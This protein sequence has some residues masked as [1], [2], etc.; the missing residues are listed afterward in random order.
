VNDEFRTLECHNSEPDVIA[1]AQKIWYLKEARMRAVTMHRTAD[2]IGDMRT[3]RDSLGAAEPAKRHRV[4]KANRGLSR[5]R[6]WS[7]AKRA[8]PAHKSLSASWRN[9]SGTD[10]AIPNAAGP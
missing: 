3:V 8:R 5:A 2:V 10:C 4:K 6:W 7:R 1:S 9:S